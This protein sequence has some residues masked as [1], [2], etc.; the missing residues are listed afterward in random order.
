MDELAAAGSGAPYCAVA[1]SATGVV[2]TELA[3]AAVDTEPIIQA[4]QIEKSYQQPD[5]RQI[6]VIAPVDFSVEPNVI[7]ALTGAIRF[8]KIDAAANSFR[9]RGA[10][11]GR[12]SVA[13]Q[14]HER[15]EPECSDRVSKFRALSRGSRC[16]KTWK[17]RCSRA[18]SVISNVT[19]GRCEALASVGLHGF[20]SAYPKELSGGM[21]QR[22]GF[23]R[24]L[25]VEPEILFMDEPFSALDVLTAENLRGE[26]LELWLAKKIPTQQH[27]HRH[28]QHRGSG[29]A[30]G[31]HHRAR[32][33]SGE[34]SRGFSRAAAA[35]ARPQVGGVC[36][37]RGLHLQSDDAAASWSLRRHRSPSTR[38]ARLRKCCRTRA[39]AAWRGLLELLNDRGG[40]EDL[41]HVAEELLLEVDDLLPILDAATLLGFATA[42]RRRRAHHAEGPRLRGSRYSD[43]Q[44]YCSAKRC[45]RMLPCCSRC[46][47]RCRRNPITPCRWNFSATCSTNVS[48]KWK[49]SSRLTPRSNWGR[50]AELF[51]YDPEDDSVHLHAPDH[52]GETSTESASLH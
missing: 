51:T 42:A 2:T 13:R 48:R 30:G 5:G 44:S 6:Q 16:W 32:T 14:A 29:A 20:E 4:K 41:Y 38:N 7:I 37:L 1:E 35:S 50:Y 10:F 11:G 40:E 22:V 21:K 17:R 8:R 33:Q 34:N 26:L 45:S 31:S 18:A 23:A 27:F 24:A 19:A 52:H 36:S 25:A 12:S 49:S 47:P 9:A 43:A 28:A 15:I 3:P 46:T 39:R